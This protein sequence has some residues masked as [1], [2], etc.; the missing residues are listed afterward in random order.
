M[1]FLERTAYRSADK[2]LA[3]LPETLEGRSTNGASHG[4][5][6]CLPEDRFARIVGSRPFD[7][8]ACYGLIG[9]T[10]D[11]LMLLHE[12]H[13]ASE[14]ARAFVLDSPTQQGRALCCRSRGHR[15]SHPGGYCV[16]RRTH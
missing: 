5:L 8:R 6:A 9:N 12:L 3:D 7:N 13:G 2:L 1:Q 10:G 15:R 4:T 14:L 16:P 11:G